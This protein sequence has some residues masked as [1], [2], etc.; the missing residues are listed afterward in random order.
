MNSLKKHFL[1]DPNVVFLNHGS[2]GATPRPVFREYQRWQRELEKQ[3][4]EFLGRRVTQLMANSRA[5]L[6][7]YL[8]TPADHLVY[9]QNVTISLNIVARSLE[10]GPGDEVLSTDHEYGA[11]DRT[12]RFLS[13]ERGFGYINQRISTPIQSE[14][15]LVEEFWRGVNSH[16]RVIAISHIASSTAIIFPIEKIIHRAREAGIIT[17]I[18]GAHGPGQIPLQLDS[19][20]VDFYGG[21]LHKWLCAPKGAGFL[22]ARPELQHLLKPLV[23]SWGYES[24]TP[25]GSTFIDEHEWWGTRDIAAFLSV[26]A[27]IEF[28]EKH[29]WDKVRGE[30]HQLARDAQ[31]RI[32]ELTGLPPLHPPA[33]GWFGQMISAP[34]PADTDTAA[35]KTK[36]YE[37]F[38]IEVPLI[39]WNGNKLIRVSVQGYNTRRDIHKLCHALSLLLN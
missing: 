25:S 27:A 32:C 5:V 36:L 10:L 8:G 22:Y 30:C 2:F 4:V 37:E 13:R 7:Q 12:W 3:P 18:D 17:I 23:V 16:T 26:P 20:G 34:L 19:L 11:I 15:S 39:E 31:G 9:T 24:E 1:L 33:D 28:L 38:W 6:G 35:L 14:E 29:N 21:N